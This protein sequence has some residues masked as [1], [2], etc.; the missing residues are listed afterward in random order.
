MF[1]V[2]FRFEKG[3]IMFTMPNST[4]YGSLLFQK[5]LTSTVVIQVFA[6]V[7]TRVCMHDRTMINTISPPFSVPTITTW[8]LEH[9]CSINI[10]HEVIDDRNINQVQHIR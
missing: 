4:K 3:K 1:S 5:S 9:M 10:Q 6:H 7:C 2:H 8:F